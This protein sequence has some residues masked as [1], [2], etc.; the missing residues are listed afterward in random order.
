M[1]VIKL[2]KEQR[3]SLIADIRDY[4]DV[5]HGETLG[6]LAAGNL[7][8]FFIQKLGP[9]VYNQ[10]LGDCRTLVGQ[11]MLSMEEDMYSLEWQQRK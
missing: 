8:D 4:F 2:P 9:S 11:R 7:L 1:K 5:E 6:E 10:A 3:D